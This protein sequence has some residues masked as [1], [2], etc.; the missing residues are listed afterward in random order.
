MPLGQLRPPLAILRGPWLS[1]ERLSSVMLTL[2]VEAKR[3][4]AQRSGIFGLKKE[5]VHL[6]S[7]EAGVTDGRRCC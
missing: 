7:G 4:N 6:A 3:N 2:G 1:V 5:S